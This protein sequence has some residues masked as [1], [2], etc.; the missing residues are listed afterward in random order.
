M[1]ASNITSLQ[2]KYLW[3]Q[4]AMAALQVNLQERTNGGF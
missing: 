3:E 1:V 4:V 2:W